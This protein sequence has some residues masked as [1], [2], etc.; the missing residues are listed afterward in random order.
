MKKTFETFVLNMCLS[1]AQIYDLEILEVLLEH[2]VEPLCIEVIRICLQNLYIVPV[3][4][5]FSSWGLGKPVFAQPTIYAWGFILKMLY[6][7]QMKGGNESSKYDEDYIKTMFSIEI[8]NELSLSGNHEYHHLLMVLK[9][10]SNDRFIWF[11]KYP[12]IYATFFSNIIANTISFNDKD[13]LLALTN[14]GYSHTKCNVLPYAITLAKKIRYNS[15]NIQWECLYKLIQISGNKYWDTISNDE[16]IVAQ[17][18]LC[19]VCNNIID[20]I[21]IGDNLLL[22]N[23]ALIN[24]SFILSTIRKNKRII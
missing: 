10:F 12:K 4:S 22:L 16:I 17:E 5:R 20:R 11:N 15:T 24:S 6:Q 13:V 14:I 23:Y 7:R 3:K 19:D 2:K 21:I 18:N 8:I 9:I 1:T